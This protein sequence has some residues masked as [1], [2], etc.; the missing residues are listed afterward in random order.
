M[1]RDNVVP[2]PRP[3]RPPAP[4]PRWRWWHKVV[5]GICVVVVA[6]GAFVVATLLIWLVKH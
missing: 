4:A 3:Y 6:V 1:P 2:F 5:V